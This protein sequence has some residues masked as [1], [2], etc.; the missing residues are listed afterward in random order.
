MKKALIL[1]LTGVFVLA[2]AIA[3]YTLRRP[4]TAEAAPSVPVAALQPLQPFFLET[5]V[6]GTRMGLIAAK[7]SDGTYRTTLNTCE[8]CFPSPR[9]YYKPDGEDLVCQNCGSRFRVDDMQVVRG[10]CNPVPLTASKVVDGQLTFSITELKGKTKYFAVP[11][12]GS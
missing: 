8:V 7:A 4:A 10:G 1:V 12:S 5:S 2:L 3:M 6:K 11:K 9:G